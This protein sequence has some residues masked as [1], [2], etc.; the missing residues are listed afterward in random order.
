MIV[1]QAISSWIRFNKHLS[2][3]T[4]NLHYEI[5][6]IWLAGELKRDRSYCIPQIPGCQFHSLKTEKASQL[7]LGMQIFNVLQQSSLEITAGRWGVKSILAR[8]YMYHTVWFATGYICN[9][10]GL[11][12]KSFKSFL[13]FSSV[14]C[15]STSPTI[16]K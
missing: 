9:N 14:N 12:K 16:Y 7:C 11:K 3:R 10:I 1:Y 15:R 4:W 6:E 13:H 5:S 2:S 8:T